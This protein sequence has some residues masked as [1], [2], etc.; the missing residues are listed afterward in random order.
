MMHENT[1]RHKTNS[2]RPLGSVYHIAQASL[3]GSHARS[4]HC[5][6]RAGPQKK[7]GTRSSI[8]HIYQISLFFAGKKRHGSFVL[9]LRNSQKFAALAKAWQNR[10]MAA[11]LRRAAPADGS[12]D[13]VDHYYFSNYFETVVKCSNVVITS[14]AFGMHEHSTN[15]TRH[16]LHSQTL[17]RQRP[18]VQALFLVLVSRCLGHGSM[19][20]LRAAA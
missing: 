13:L 17:V 10:R 18:A 15:E 9:L 6:C 16:S 4:Q 2:P 11:W 8:L 7:W 5:G 12:G 20:G 19:C 3:A 14:L 1:P